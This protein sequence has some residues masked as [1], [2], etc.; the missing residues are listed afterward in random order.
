MARIEEALRQRIAADLIALGVPREMV[1]G[2]VKCRSGRIDL[3]I[4]TQPRCLIE[5]KAILQ[6]TACG[7]G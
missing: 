2:E 5:L 6:P 1:E 3:V 4:Y 7:L